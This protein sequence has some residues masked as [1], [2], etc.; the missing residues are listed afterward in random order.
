V[1]QR[2]RPPDVCI[3]AEDGSFTL[4]TTATD[5]GF[6]VLELDEDD[7]VLHIE[8]AT[9]G[10]VREAGRYFHHGPG[11]EPLALVADRAARVSGTVVDSAGV[12]VPL[13][14][15][16]LV[17]NSN[18]HRADVNGFPDQA[19]ASADTASDGTFVMGRLDGHLGLHLW[20]RIT[21]TTG[22]HG[23]G[24]F[25]VGPGQTVALGT[26]TMSAPATIEGTI[27][28][29]AGRPRCGIEVYL[30]RHDPAG[31]PIEKLWR[32]HTGHLGCYG[33]HGLPPGDYS[34]LV[35]SPHAMHAPWPDYGR[36]TLRAG[37]HAVVTRLT[38]W[39]WLLILSLL[40]AV[41]VAMT[42][43]WMVR[44]SMQRRRMLARRRWH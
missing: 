16:E 28:D 40:V 2:R 34:V 31:P 37:E 5:S 12:P 3:T 22:T 24:P 1:A 19:V 14:Q 4:P 29:Q 35:D 33:F 10:R 15:V 36:V 43:W 20:F 41:P 30:W 21:S 13:A 25:E 44:S 11:L 8:G 26:I 18:E 32:S 7:Y 17:V 27:L 39:N 6:F 23:G 38:R 9:E 42:C